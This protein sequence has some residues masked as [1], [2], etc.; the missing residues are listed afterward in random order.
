MGLA[1]NA[2]TGEVIA[3]DGTTAVEGEEGSATLSQ[4]K[5]RHS[6]R[7]HTMQNTVETVKRLK[8]SEMKK[9]R[10]LRF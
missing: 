9:A 2:E 6:R 3:T 10:Y 4:L 5:I 7:T 1:I 8:S